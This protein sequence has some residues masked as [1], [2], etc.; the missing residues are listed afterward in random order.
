MLAGTPEDAALALPSD[1]EI[2]DVDVTRSGPFGNPFRLGGFRARVR[3]VVELHRRWLDSRPARAAS[4]VRLSDGSPIPRRMQPTQEW[5]DWT[6]FDVL[7]A[8]D[9]LVARYPDADAFRLHCSPSCKGR[10]CHGAT[11]A[12]ELR[13]FLAANSA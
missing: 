1:A 9:D 5:A 7:D 3:E 4:A 6:S 10:L 11:V 12:S 2:V 8:F 13:L